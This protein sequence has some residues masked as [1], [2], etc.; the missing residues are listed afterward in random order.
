MVKCTLSS[1][2]Y[3]I[4]KTKGHD[5][6]AETMQQAAARWVS[7]V[8]ESGRY[9]LWRFAMCLNVGEVSRRSAISSHYFLGGC[10]GGPSRAL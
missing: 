6:L 4:T 1:R 7:A 8:N 5:P 2:Q 3:L 10:A 9:G